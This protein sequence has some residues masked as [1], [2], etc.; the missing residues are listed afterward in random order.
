MEHLQISAPEHCLLCDNKAFTTVTNLKDYF[1]S[2]EE[3]AIYKC[4]NCGLLVTRPM[5][6][7]SS[8]GKYYASENYISHSDNKKDAFSIAYRLI[9]NYTHGRKYKLIR[10]FNPVKSVLDIGCATG[11][12]LN[13]C[14]KKGLQ[15]MGIEPN[16]KARNIAETTYKLDIKDEHEIDSLDNE[17]FDVITMWHVLEHVP[18]I[19]KR[20]S[21]IFR[22]LKDKGLA[23]IALPNHASHDAQ[24]YNRYWAAWDVPRHLFHFDQKAFSLL[25]TKHGFEIVSIRPMLFDAFYVSLLSEKYMSGKSSYPKAIRRG[26]I[27][28]MKARSGTKD[29]SSLIYIIKKI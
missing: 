5:P 3:F 18:D 8:L 23:Y 2:G 7:L 28:N 19:N 11:E 14:A 1:L 17:S 21:D 20:M 12:F 29:Y 15:T 27:S 9:R 10:S 24:Y 22:L 6:E 13:F 25:A 26:L 4:T 16:E